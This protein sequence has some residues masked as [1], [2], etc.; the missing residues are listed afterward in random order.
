[1]FEEKTYESLMAD[2][3]ALVSSDYDKREGSILHFALGANSAEAAQMYITLEWMFLQMFG[4]TAEREYLKKIAYDTRGIVPEPATHAVLKGKFNIEVKEGTRF[5]QEELNYYVSDFLE[6]KEG[7]FYYKVICETAGEAG[8][9]NFGDMIPIDYVPGLATCE[10][11]EVLVPGEDEEDTEVFRQRWRDSFNAAAFGGNR[12]DYKIKIKAIE[13]VGGVKCYRATNAEGEKVGGY[14]R[15]VVIASDYSVP[16]DVLIDSIQT[17]IDPEQ[18]HAE[19]DGLAPIGHS[20]TIAGA[21]GVEVAVSTTITF[22]TGYTFTD[23]KSRIEAAVEAYLLSLRKD[24]EDSETGLV[25]R[26]KQI[27]AAI[28]DVNGVLD[29]AGTKLNGQEE[30]IQLGIDEIPLR[31]D[32][33]G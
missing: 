1:M 21:T 3:M 26:I 18:N 12:A 6:E 11:T 23:I 10:L 22:D 29:V 15:C 8:N 17:I 4:D 13:G 2:K 7:F 14:V 9:R 25:V 5:S 27:E 33:S 28:L 16:S 24:W 20:V 31:G 19:G 30:N 32:I